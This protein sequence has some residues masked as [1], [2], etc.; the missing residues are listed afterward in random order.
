MIPSENLI[1]SRN[2]D[3]TVVDGMTDVTS[4]TPL[5]SEFSMKILALLLTLL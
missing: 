1:V 5:D 4:G 3:V 2:I